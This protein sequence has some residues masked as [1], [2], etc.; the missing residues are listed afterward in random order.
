MLPFLPKARLHVFFSNKLYN[1]D[2][3]CIRKLSVKCS[4]LLHKHTHEELWPLPQQPSL[5]AQRHWLFAPWPF[6]TPTSRNNAAKLVGFLWS[7]TR[8]QKNL[9]RFSRRKSLHRKEVYLGLVDWCLAN[10]SSFPFCWLW[11]AL[12]SRSKGRSSCLRVGTCNAFILRSTNLS[13]RWERA[14]G[15]SDKTR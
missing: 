12:D 13:W 10:A 8:S 1:I 11:Q 9:Q 7:W 6:G 2:Q 3:H 15:Q 5:F 14:L 4:Q